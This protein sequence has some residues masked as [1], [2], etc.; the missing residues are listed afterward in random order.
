M[1]KEIDNMF[2]DGTNPKLATSALVGE[3]A[4]WS[5][6]QCERLLQTEESTLENGATS[7]VTLLDAFG[8]RL[9]HDAKFATVSLSLRLAS[10]VIYPF[11]S[12]I[13]PSVSTKSRPRTRI[14][15]SVFLLRC[16]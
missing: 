1:L 2:E 6:G 8:R 5:L 4:H 14:A 10:H 12:Y 16:S 3:I 7:L 15:S 11:A 13:S 9:F